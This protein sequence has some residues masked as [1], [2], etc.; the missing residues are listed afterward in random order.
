MG[1]D[2]VLDGPGGAV[3]VY[4]SDGTN[5]TAPTSLIHTASTGTTGIDALDAE[6]PPVGSWG[7]TGDGTATPV[8][9]YYTGAEWVRLDPFGTGNVSWATLSEFVGDGDAVPTDGDWA[10]VDSAGTESAVDGVATLAAE[11]GGNYSL[12]SGTRAESLAVGVIARDLS[13]DMDGGTAAGDKVTTLRPQ[14]TISGDGKYWTLEVRGNNA[15]WLATGNTVTSIG[16]AK[17]T[18]LECA[19]LYVDP[20]TNAVRVYVDR[21]YTPAYSGTLIGAPTGTTAAAIFLVQSAAAA[22]PSMSFS[23]HVVVRESS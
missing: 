8:W 12:I 18:A 20:A 10:I 9:W 21:A 7:L 13:V 23:R 6:G 17:T 4:A 11:A 16:V 3:R 22:E 19:E 14:A 1:C 2:L 5:W 15:N